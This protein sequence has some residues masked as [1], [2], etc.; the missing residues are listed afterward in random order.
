METQIFHHAKKYNL[1]KIPLKRNQNPSRYYNS[2][3]NLKFQ[4]NQGKAQ[5]EIRFK[6]LQQTMFWFKTPKNLEKTSTR[7]F[8]KTNLVSA[9]FL[10]TETDERERERVSAADVLLAKINS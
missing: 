5:Q 10:L 3:S 9:W 2:L 1:Q 8:Q 6:Q 4:Y 7:M